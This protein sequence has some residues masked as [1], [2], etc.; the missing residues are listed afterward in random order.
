MSQGFTRSQIINGIIRDDRTTSPACFENNL[1]AASAALRLGTTLTAHATPHTKGSYTDIIA[2]TGQTAYGIWVTGFDVAVNGSA[3]SML[4]D[5]ATGGI[6]AETDIISNIDMGNASV[7]L[8]TGVTS[9][10]KLF[11]FPGLLIPSGTRISAR[12]QA[13]ITVDTLVVAM[14]LDQR[15]QWQ[16]ANTSWVTYGA[17][18]AS[19]FGTAVPKGTNAFGAW[20]AVGS[21]TSRSHTLWTVGLD[22]LADTTQA[23]SIPVLIE[24]GYGPNAGSITSIGVVQSLLSIQEASAGCFPP[25]LA[26][27]VSSGS[28]LWARLAGDDT[29]NRGVIIYG[30]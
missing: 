9:N 5:I 7:S 19:S 21:T 11:Y 10:G 6:G 13:L 1:T 30:N 15:I 14:S 29:E 27:N 28:Q 12:I 25:V 24:I 4:L 26:F 18:T 23:A 17:V 22:M 3:T 8:S 16:I 20:T 2:S